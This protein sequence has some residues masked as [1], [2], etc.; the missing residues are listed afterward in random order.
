L[1]ASITENLLIYPDHNVI[2]YAQYM[3]IAH[4]KFLF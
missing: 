4:A 2:L 3:L 1:R